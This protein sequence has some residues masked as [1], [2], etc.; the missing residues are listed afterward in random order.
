MAYGTL[1][2]AVCKILLTVNSHRRETA[3]KTAAVRVVEHK[4][5]CLMAA[6]S[7]L[8][9]KDKKIHGVEHQR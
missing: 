7:A 1:V 2:I 9:S 4:V 6:G 3:L 5:V 8:E